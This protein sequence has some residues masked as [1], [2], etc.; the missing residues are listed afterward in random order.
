MLAVTLCATALAS[1]KMPIIGWGSWDEKG[2]SAERYAEA[3]DTGFTHLTQWCTSSAEAKRLHGEAEKAGIKLIVGLGH[4][5]K[6]MTDA[7]LDM[8]RA[9]TTR[10]GTSAGVSIVEELK[11]REK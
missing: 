3:R 4:D 9:G 10:I 11:A 2:A 6:R 7:V 8:I 5:V 1:T